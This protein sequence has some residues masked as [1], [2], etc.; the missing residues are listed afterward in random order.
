MQAHIQVAS[1]LLAG[2]T[3]NL[4]AAC[5]P[6]TTGA[7]VLRMLRAWANRGNKQMPLP[8]FETVPGATPKQV[9]PDLGALKF[10]AFRQLGWRCKASGS[11]RGRAMKD[12]QP[13]CSGMV[14]RSSSSRPPCIGSIA[15][16]DVFL[17][18][19]G[20]YLKQHQYHVVTAAD[21][22]TTLSGTLLH[23][24]VL[25]CAVLCNT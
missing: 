5:N 19:L 12:T 17:E 1:W 9:C 2:E 15:P 16:Q 24:A 11:S 14:W 6:P 21:L 23:F 13:V 7:A 8:T 22:W 18:G 20:Q 4:P 25:C 3:S 10:T